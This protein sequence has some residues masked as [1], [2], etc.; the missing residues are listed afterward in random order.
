VVGPSIGSS[1][2]LSPLRG[3]GFEVCLSP[4]RCQFKSTDFRTNLKVLV[5]IL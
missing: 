5:Y 4:L 2:P 3:S 1:F